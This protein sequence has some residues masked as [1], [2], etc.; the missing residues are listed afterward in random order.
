MRLKAQDVAAAEVGGHGFPAGAG[1]GGGAFGEEAVR[2]AEG[3]VEEGFFEEGIVRVDCVEGGGG[4]EVEF[5]G[6]DS[7]YRSWRRLE[8]ERRWAERAC[9]P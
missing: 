2:V 1:A 6:S 7:D 8:E 5:V 4:G 3:V 9:V